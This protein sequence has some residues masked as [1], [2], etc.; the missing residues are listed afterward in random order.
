MGHFR[1][2]SWKVGRV[3]GPGPG[4]TCTM[5]RGATRGV[6]LGW[7]FQELAEKVLWA[8]QNQKAMREMGEGESGEEDSSLMNLAMPACHIQACASC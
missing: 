1:A 4:L 7:L 3:E 5:T 6:K 2:T 8:K